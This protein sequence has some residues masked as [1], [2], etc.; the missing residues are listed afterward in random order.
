MLRVEVENR[1][2]FSMWEKRTKIDLTQ[3]LSVQQEEFVIDGI[4]VPLYAHEGSAAV[5]L[6]IKLFIHRQQLWYIRGWI[7]L[8]LGLK[9]SKNHYKYNRLRIEKKWPSPSQICMYR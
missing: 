9:S 1:I 7:M 8:S 6:Q 5:A 3:S 4:L 2:Y